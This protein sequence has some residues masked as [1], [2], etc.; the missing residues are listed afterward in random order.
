MQKV[1]LV[2]VWIAEICDSCLHEVCGNEEAVKQS[3]AELL[4]EGYREK[5]IRIDEVSVRI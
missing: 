3:K 4:K 5:D 1:F 2:Y